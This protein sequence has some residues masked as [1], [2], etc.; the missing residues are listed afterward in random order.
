MQVKAWLTRYFQNQTLFDGVSGGFSFWIFVSS[1]FP[2]SPLLFGFG[3]ILST[4]LLKLFALVA[5][6]ILAQMVHITHCYPVHLP[7]NKIVLLAPGI[8]KKVS[9]MTPNSFILSV[10]AQAAQTCFMTTYNYYICITVY[11]LYSNINVVMKQLWAACST[12]TWC[13]YFFVTIF[14]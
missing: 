8:L 11:V 13:C 2:D 5:F 1:T 9:F 14:S 6:G 4:R 12:I 3:D 10:L 7:K